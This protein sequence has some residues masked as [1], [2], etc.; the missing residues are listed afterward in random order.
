[1]DL[2]IYSFIAV[3]KSILTRVKRNK[4]W[5]FSSFEIVREEGV[6]NFNIQNEPSIETYNEPSIELKPH[7]FLSDYSEGI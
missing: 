6:R 2:P 1:M 7:S 5:R 3:L 4:I